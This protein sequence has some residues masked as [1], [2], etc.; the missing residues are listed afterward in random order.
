[1]DSKKITI[2]FTCGVYDLLHEGHIKFLTRCKYYC[3]YLIVA[4]V[5]DYFVKV[6][7]GHKRP[8]QSIKERI[9]N[10]E[11]SNLCDKIIKV[12]TLDM[13]EY[14]KIADIFFRGIE[15]NNMR[16]TYSGTTILIPRTPGIS[17]T[18]IIKERNNAT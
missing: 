7:K 6:Q 18:K 3:N 12:D 2:G 10:L 15:Q 16:Y 17:T 1:M 5:S 9:S 14:L 4:V 11:K 13:T 8:I